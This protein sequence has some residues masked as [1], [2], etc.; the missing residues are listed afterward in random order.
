MLKSQRS[1]RAA[2]AVP[3]ARLSRPLTVLRARRALRDV[4]R[5]G[6]FDVVVCHQPWIYVIFGPV[7]R[8]AGLPVV[9]WVHM[10]SDGR[11]WLERLCR[12]TRPDLALCNSQFTAERT[13]TWL[14]ET[15]IDY[16]YC[17]VSTSQVPQRADATIEAAGDRSRHRPT[18]L[19]WCR[20]AG[21]SHSKGSTY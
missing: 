17:P 11:H 12:L 9:L 14:P 21:W 6:S 13:S 3:S 18:M 4:L 8:G 15:S 20:S 16:A 1:G 19:W 10:A 7:V 5:L 2:H